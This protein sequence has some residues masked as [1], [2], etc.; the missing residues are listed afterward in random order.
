MNA[1]TRPARANGDLW[2][3]SLSAACRILTC[4]LVV[5]TTYV[6]SFDASHETILPVPTTLVQRWV[7]SLLRWDAFHFLGV[8]K[9][10]YVHEYEYAFL[11]GLPVVARGLA[12]FMSW[13]GVKTALSVEGILAAG[14]LAAVLCDTTYDLYQLTL[15]YTSSHPV[16][17]LTTMLSLLSSSP[18]TLRHAGYT[19]P[20][21][22]FFSYKGAL[23]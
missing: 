7:S 1:S 17:T 2:P 16:A 14:A 23:L 11:P 6:P 9:N 5:L 22:A 18:A 15:H 19:E 13:L 8:A 20:F 3:L 21:F 10:G 4:V 12:T